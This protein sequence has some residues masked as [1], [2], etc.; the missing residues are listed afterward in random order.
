MH[1]LTFLNF[2]TN[3]IQT[4][5]PFN[6]Q[7]ILS[8]PLR[9]IRKIY[10]K[11]VELPINFYNVRNNFNSF[12]LT[13]YKVSSPIAF[14]SFTITVDNNNYK[15]LAD[16]FNV[17]NGQMYGITMPGFTPSDNPYFSVNAD[18]TITLSNT[19]LDLRFKLSSSNFLTQIL[20]FTNTL[21][22]QLCKYNYKCKNI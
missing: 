5:N 14:K 1:H 11:S 6:S 7:F 2:D 13:L 17:L 9:K 3:L 12:N 16:L 10:L 21:L 22:F 19:N 20:G 15:T 4:S 8:D 18:N